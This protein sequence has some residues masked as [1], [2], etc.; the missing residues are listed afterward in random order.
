M[1][2]ASEMPANQ[3]RIN[4]SLNVLKCLAVFGVICIHC[5]V[6][7]I[8]FKGTVI[9]SLF[10]F[11]VPVFFLTSGFYSYFDNNEKAV[12]KYKTRIEKLLVLFL[13][14]NVIYFI[15][16]CY[17]TGNYN[18]LAKLIEM[19]S[20]SNC[21]KYL[22]F[23]VS[24]TYAHLWFIQALIY[25]YI[26]FL[27]MSRLNIPHD[28]LYSYIP[29]L[30]LGA[31]FIGEI[32]CLMGFKFSYYF[33]RNFLFMGLP[34][35]TMGY[36]IHDKKDKFTNISDRTIYITIILSCCLTVLEALT[37]SKSEIYIGTIFLSVMLIVWCI[38]HPDRDIKII[39]WIGGN[40]YLLIYVIHLMIIK[41]INITFIH[42]H[43]DLGYLYPFLIFIISVI[44]S[45]LILGL[46]KLAG[47]AK[48][49]FY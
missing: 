17:V 11:A 39:G 34:F 26:I 24:P 32:S 37:V 40:L 10:R 4:K 13:I 2:N 16:D 30:L 38:K 25:C 35:F 7:K 1:H 20:I 33:Y 23:N 44:V 31:I 46:I 19:F 3:K 48:S 12:R 9:D 41:Y 43:G 21:Y 15:F 5:S 28:K 18:I 6:Y 49:Y 22:I 36:L 8:G 42:L 27:I 45:T 47:K 14:S 29:L